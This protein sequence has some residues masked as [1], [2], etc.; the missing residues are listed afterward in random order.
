[1]T[2]EETQKRLKEKKPDEPSWF[3]DQNFDHLNAAESW[4]ID[5]DRW[6]EMSDD[7]RGAVIAVHRARRKMD[8]WE[9]YFFRPKSK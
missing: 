4:G 5:A 7:G 2:L 3:F 8:A 9:S 1:M 6:D